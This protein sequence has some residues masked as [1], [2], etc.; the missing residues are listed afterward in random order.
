MAAVG[1][2]VGGGA[3]VILIVILVVI[4]LRR[5]TKSKISEE[6]KHRESMI[7]ESVNPLSK[8]LRET[9]ISSNRALFKTSQEN[10]NKIDNSDDSYEMKTINERY[11]NLSKVSANSSTK[12]GTIKL[13]SPPQTPTKPT[14]PSTAT[15]N[16]V[17]ASD[18]YNESNRNSNS[19]NNSLYNARR[20]LDEPK[21]N[22]YDQV[23]LGGKRPDSDGVQEEIDNPYE[24]VRKKT[25]ENPYDEV[26][27]KTGE[28]PYD[29]VKKNPSGTAYAT[30]RNFSE[31]ERNRLESNASGVYD[32][33]GPIK[34]GAGRV[35]DSDGLLYADLNSTDAG[36]SGTTGTTG[37]TKHLN[38]GN[39]GA[40]RTS[41]HVYSE[42]RKIE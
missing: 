1:A 18:N 21:E 6:D 15:V 3:V 33:V 28:N 29:E 16:L 31:E 14:K 25:D 41:D 10:L 40:R 24:E 37:A 36:G 30:I 39:T 22:P 26:K 4:V 12:D 9:R 17:L 5:R 35:I 20:D 23:A 27:K 38:V 42:P 2:G 32:H 19:T 7:A 8:D 34:I 11:S 13:N